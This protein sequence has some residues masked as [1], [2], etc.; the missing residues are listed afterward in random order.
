MLKE[1][2]H[3]VIIIMKVIYSKKV[4]TQK[5]KKMKIRYQIAKI[6]NLILKIRELH[7]VLKINQ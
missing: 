2:D 1:K 6:K 3:Q 4:L 7:L 5:I